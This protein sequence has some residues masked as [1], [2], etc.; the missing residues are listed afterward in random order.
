MK[1]FCAECDHREPHSPIH[2]YDVG[3]ELLKQATLGRS[4]ANFKP[5]SYPRFQ[6]F[7][8]QYLCQGKRTLQTFVVRRENWELIL[9][10]RSPMEHVEVPS[11]IPKPERHLFRDALIAMHGGKPLAALSYLRAFTEQFARRFTGLVGKVTGEEIMA[12]YSESLPSAHRDP[13]PSLRQWCERL[14]EAVHEAKDDSELAEQT[15]AETERHFDIRRVF[16]IPK[17]SPSGSPR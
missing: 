6:L 8:L 5:P 15:R 2:C 4:L 1:V 11:F 3:N 13:M 7:V 12:A 9:E 16:R 10:G 14:S 17:R